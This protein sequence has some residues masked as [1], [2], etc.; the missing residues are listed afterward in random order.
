MQKSRKAVC[1]LAIQIGFNQFVWVATYGLRPIASFLT[2]LMYEALA[3]GISLTTQ[4][5]QG[6]QPA[7]PSPLPPC[8]QIAG[9]IEWCG[10]SAR[11]V[12]IATA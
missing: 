10:I 6:P 9:V 1:L 5:L 4:Y 3:G 7:A 11:R 2:P 8:L 12:V